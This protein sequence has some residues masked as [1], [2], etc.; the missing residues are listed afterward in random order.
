LTAAPGAGKRRRPSL[1][2][3]LPHDA[4]FPSRQRHL[5]DVASPSTPPAADRRAPRMPPRRP[6]HLPPAF[7]PF[8][9][10]TTR[11][12]MDEM[13]RARHGLP[14]SATPDTAA[15]ALP[16]ADP[17]RSGDLHHHAHAPVPDR[18]RHAAGARFAGES[19]RRRA[20]PPP[21]R[22]PPPPSPLP[23]SERWVVQ[24]PRASGLPLARAPAAS[25]LPH[26]RH[27][28]GAVLAAR[29]RH[30]PMCSFD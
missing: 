16:A 3:R 27:Q 10:S 9:G 14:T 17:P 2:M 7:P 6:P 23:V 12:C 18:R 11:R 26:P 24:D 28:R 15:A 20:L 8:A 1:A 5:D 4:A 25:N 13:A 29:F 21:H 19:S 22:Y 30:R